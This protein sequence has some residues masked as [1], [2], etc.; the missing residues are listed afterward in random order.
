MIEESTDDPENRLLPLHSE[1][2]ASKARINGS[3]M[4]ITA[5]FG[6]TL[7]GLVLKDI[8]GK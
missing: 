5:I 1:R 8:Y 2:D 6:L 7:A 3:I 4:H